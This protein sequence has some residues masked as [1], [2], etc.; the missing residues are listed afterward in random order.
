MAFARGPCK[1]AVRTPREGYKT[2]LPARPLPGP[3]EQ[4]DGAMRITWQSQRPIAAPRT[5]AASPHGSRLPRCP[6]GSHKLACGRS[7][8]ARLSDW[9][10]GANALVSATGRT[11]ADGG[12]AQ[13]PP[14]LVFP[15]T[16]KNEGEMI[17][18][19]FSDEARHQW[20]ADKEAKRDA[21]LKALQPKPIRRC[22]ANSAQVRAATRR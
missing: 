15:R 10:R 22:N 17:G 18:K 6:E 1:R 12:A 20:F 11:A 21:A 19:E 14:S 3:A 2:S 9:F 13:E 8:N 5:P 7:R 16:P 4:C